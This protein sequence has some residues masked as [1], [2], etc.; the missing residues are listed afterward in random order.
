MKRFSE[1]TLSK[2]EDEDICSDD[3]LWLGLPS[4]VV[5]AAMT[6][7]EPLHVKR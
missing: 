4:G 1:E 3:S 5:S 2:D 7:A 6:F